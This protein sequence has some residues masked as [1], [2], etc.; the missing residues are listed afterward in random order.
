MS[1]LFCIVGTALLMISVILCAVT[2]NDEL[3]IACL[4]IGEVIAFLGYAP[5][6]FRTLQT[7]VGYSVRK[8]D[9]YLLKLRFAILDLQV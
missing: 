4:I 3:W 2:D 1:L 8:V 6:I 9:Q 7:K 5:I